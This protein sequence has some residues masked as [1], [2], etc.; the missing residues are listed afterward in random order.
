VEAAVATTAA[1]ASVNCVSL[2]MLGLVQRPEGSKVLAQEGELHH[3]GE[4]DGQLLVAGR[5][6]ATDF[7]PAHAAFDGVAPAV[8]IR[9]EGTWAAFAHVAALARSDNRPDPASAEVGEHARKYYV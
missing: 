3:G 4:V 8:E 7:Q 5:D 6:G 2:S 9:I 1:M